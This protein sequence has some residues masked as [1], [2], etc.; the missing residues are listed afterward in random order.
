[1]SHRIHIICTKP[2]ICSLIKKALSRYDYIISCNSGEAINEDS[3]TRFEE[4]I[5]CLI[6][7]KNINSDIKKKAKEF[8]NKSFV[9]YLPSLEPVENS[10]DDVKNISAHLRLSE[11]S[12]RLESLFK[13]NKS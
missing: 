9:I 4:S 6:I 10:F 7:D 12:E 2:E 13:F 5:D 1:M 8:F 3:I 11:L